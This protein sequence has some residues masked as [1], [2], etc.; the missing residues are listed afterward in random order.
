M[1]W[2]I[3]PF[4][5]GIVSVISFSLIS[6]YGNR[7]T[8]P[9]YVKLAAFVSWTFP[10]SIM[11]LVPFDISSTLCQGH[12]DRNCEQSF[13]YLSESV[14]RGLW[15]TVYWTMFCL[16]WFAIP[17]MQ[18]YVL[19]GGFTFRQKFRGSVKSN[20]VYYGILGSVGFVALIYIVSSGRVRKWEELRAFIMAAAN[21][22]GMVL[23]M[24][25]MGHGLV[26]IPRNLWKCGN[27][28]RALRIAEV[29]ATELKDNSY[30]AN[31]EL[32]E[33]MRAINWVN[34]EV[35]RNSELRPY[36]DQIIEKCPSALQTTDAEMHGYSSREI[37]LK[38]LNN[39]HRQVI[40]A[41]RQSNRCASQW[42]F[43]LKR[44]FLLQDIL[45]NES[46]SDKRFHSTV[47]PLTNGSHDDFKRTLMWWWYIR[48]QPSLCRI[49]SI[50]TAILSISLVWSEITFMSTKPVLS[51]FGLVSR[52]AENT[53][54]VLEWISFFTIAYMCICAYTSLFK[55]KIFNLY[56]L[57]PNQN[58]NEGSLL[59]FG[60]YLCRLTY[61]LC[62]NYLNITHRRDTV[63]S[64]FMGIINL[65]PLLGEQFNNW[66]P[67]LILLPVLITLFNIHGRVLGAF[68]VGSYFEDDEGDL[69]SA[70]MEE[71]RQ[72]ILEARS[73]VERKLQRGEQRTS[74]D[75]RRVES[76]A[77]PS[78]QRPTAAPSRTSASPRE[79]V[80]NRFLKSITSWT[81]R[82]SNR[83]EHFSRLSTSNP[84]SSE[85]DD[86]RL[87]FEDDDEDCLLLDRDTTS[88]D[89]SR[90]SPTR[91]DS[92]RGRAP[93]RNFW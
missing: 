30:D 59:F 44:A 12:Q 18:S 53:Q 45:E 81:R 76:R 23:V 49:L 25:F 62:Y 8:C 21:S 47:R 69:G 72:L 61:P 68:S 48:L 91:G 84:D 20:L 90:D 33:V 42:E 93:P 89:Q 50:V 22:W 85:P 14:L 7:K 57:V 43:H 26:E 65:T 73:A 70:D 16:T 46:S 52:A 34:H 60:G 29:K 32:Q 88:P 40:R 11:F 31:L 36:V 9:W 10:L 28:R 6:Y 87:S 56:A 83:G 5:F 41:V 77:A 82:P 39:L 37:N 3:V 24:L 80:V 35:Q 74:L 27:R 78:H 19:S 15:R 86:I 75:G 2:F 66:V 17:L 64:K 67:L 38:Y 51:I 4:C 54:G 63:F 55:L 1:A 13:A 92:R 79:G 71:G 58:T